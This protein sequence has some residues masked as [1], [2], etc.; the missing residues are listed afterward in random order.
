MWAMFLPLPRCLRMSD[1]VGCFFCSLA[2]TSNTP[3]RPPANFLAVLRLYRCDF[4]VLMLAVRPG[5]QVC[6]S[7][8]NHA[9]LSPFRMK[10]EA[11]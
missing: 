7:L 10:A 6:I 9:C 4:Q 1:Q 2:L 5:C 3:R 8:M 11:F